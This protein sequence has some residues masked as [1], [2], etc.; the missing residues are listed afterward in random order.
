MESALVEGHWLAWLWPKEPVCCI[1]H[2]VFFLLSPLVI[3][4]LRRQA[5]DQHGRA[6]ASI[7]GG[8]LFCTFGA[9]TW[10][11]HGF[12][13]DAI[14]Q[15][16]YDR[17]DHA[18][19]YVMIAATGTLV[20]SM[21]DT[22]MAKVMLVIVWLLAAVGFWCKLHYPMTSREMTI[23]LYIGMGCAV[24]PCLPALW[25]KLPV[26]GL[27]LFMGGNAFYIVGALIWAAQWP[28]LWPGTFGHHELMHLVI[29]T[30][31]VNHCLLM[32]WYVVTQR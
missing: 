32:R 8:A 25:R 20:F 4:D 15:G 19:I 6:M 13:C 1:T 9:S 21:I 23:A 30:G 10:C 27:E 11:H 22:R 5:I 24:T 26:T 12:G 29:G 17:I 14:M 7:Y 3:L 18:C 31:S 2:L 16:L 28:N